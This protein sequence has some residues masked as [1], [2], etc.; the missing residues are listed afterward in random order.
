MNEKYSDEYIAIENRNIIAHD[1]DLQNLLNSL[2][3][4]NKNDILIEFINKRTV[5]FIN[6]NLKYFPIES[7]RL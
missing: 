1:I 3:N 2:N 5:C 7:N 6:N 4:K